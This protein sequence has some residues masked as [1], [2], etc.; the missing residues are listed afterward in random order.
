MAPRSLLELPAK[1]GG[2]MNHDHGCCQKVTKPSRPPAAVS[3]GKLRCSTVQGGYIDTPACRDTAIRISYIKT[4]L[5]EAAWDTE[6]SSTLKD[7]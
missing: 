7:E 4:S 2:S 3:I 1:K 6:N 5:A